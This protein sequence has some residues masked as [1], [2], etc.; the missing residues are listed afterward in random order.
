M[1]N[2]FVWRKSFPIGS[3]R[4][5]IVWSD[6]AQRFVTDFQWINPADGAVVHQHV[7]TALTQAA[8]LLFQVLGIFSPGINTSSVWSDHR[9]GDSTT[10]MV[11]SAISY[12]QQIKPRSWLGP[13]II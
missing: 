5:A 1:V 10:A 4:L 9:R 8:E 6:R 13:M 3:Q 2:Q 7:E 11:F 12:V